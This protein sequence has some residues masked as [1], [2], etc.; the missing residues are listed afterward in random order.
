MVSLPIRRNLS[1]LRNGV[2]SV[3]PIKERNETTRMSQI[4]LLERVALDEDNPWNIA[5]AHYPALGSVSEQ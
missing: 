2:N 1:H 4:S 5:E 3:T